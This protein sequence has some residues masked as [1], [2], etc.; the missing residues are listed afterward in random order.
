MGHP[1]LLTT[2]VFTLPAAVPLRHGILQH[3]RNCQ[4]HVVPWSD[5]NSTINQRLPRRFRCGGAAIKLTRSSRAVL[6][7]LPS[8]KIPFCECVH[9][10]NSSLLVLCMEGRGRRCSSSRPRLHDLS[11]C[12]RCVGSPHVQGSE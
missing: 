5:L 8:W 6:Q 10:C 9:S 4:E 1:P 3:R 11:W 7:V 12:T 2:P